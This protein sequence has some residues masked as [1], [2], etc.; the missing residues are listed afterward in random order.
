MTDT[1]NPR[2]D[3]DQLISACC[4]GD[5]AA[6]SELR[7]ALRPGVRFLLERSGASPSLAE[8]ILAQVLREVADGVVIRQSELLRRTRHAVRE[9]VTDPARPRSSSYP[10][11][12]LAIPDRDREMLRRYYVDGETPESIC[13]RLSTSRAAF[14]AARHRLRRSLPQSGGSAGR[15]NRDDSF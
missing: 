7:N 15:S 9:I 4:A 6:C 3:L 1:P 5:S 12:R 2:R 11:L 10:G 14:E 8:G 13:R